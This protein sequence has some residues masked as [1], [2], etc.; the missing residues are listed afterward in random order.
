MAEP[1]GGLDELAEEEINKLTAE[2]ES[3]EA[4]GAGGKIA[5]GALKSFHKMF[6]KNLLKRGR[7]TG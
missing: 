2:S 5:E 7:E 1:K 4:E 3:N 6:E